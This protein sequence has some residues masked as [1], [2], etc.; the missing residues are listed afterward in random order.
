MV[1][2]SIKKHLGRE[3][4]V[5]GRD[6]AVPLGNKYKDPD[7]VGQD[8]LIGAFATQQLY[9][10]PAVIVDFGTAITLDVLST[11]GNYEGGVIVPGIRLSLESLHSKTALLPQVEGVRRPRRIIGKTTEQSILSGLVYGYGEMCRGLIKRIAAD[12]GVQ[13]QVVVTGGYAQLMVQF[14]QDYRP[15]VDKYL[16]HKGLMLLAR[17]QQTAGTDPLPKP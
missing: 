12:L 4:L 7:Q 6:M 2:R 3:S 1:Q 8:R 11:A 9:G 16:V 5:V 14:L 17:E 10:Q 15:A 13:P